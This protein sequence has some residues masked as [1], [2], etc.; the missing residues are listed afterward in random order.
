MGLVTVTSFI[1]SANI[2]VKIIRDNLTRSLYLYCQLIT[3]MTKYQVIFHIISANIEV[4]ITWQHPVTCLAIFLQP[5]QRFTPYQH[6]FIIIKVKQLETLSSSTNLFTS[7]PVMTEFQQVSL[8]YHFSQ[9]LDFLH[10]V[11]KKYAPKYIPVFQ[12]VR[13]Q[14]S[15]LTYQCLIKDSNQIRYIVFIFYCILVG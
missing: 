10:P 14:N 12:C 3:V 6:Y 2:K 11:L 1:L 9:N 4:K 8:S 13:V 7:L 5:W 15:L